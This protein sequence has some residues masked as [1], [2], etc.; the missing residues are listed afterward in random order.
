MYFTGIMAKRKRK[1]TDTMFTIFVDL[2]CGNGLL[3]HILSSEG[4]G[5]AY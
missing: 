3:V 1:E 2:G 5:L 4:V